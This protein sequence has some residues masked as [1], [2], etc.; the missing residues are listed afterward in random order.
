MW[1][2]GK[3]V[4]IFF[5]SKIRKENDALH[6]HRRE[7]NIKTHLGAVVLW[8]E[9]SWYIVGLLYKCCKYGDDSSGSVQ[10]MTFLTR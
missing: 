9:I 8:S 6:R 10:V 2:N 4:H 5:F 1:E 3:S 7:G